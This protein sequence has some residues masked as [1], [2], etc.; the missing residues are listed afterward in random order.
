M[1]LSTTPE[2]LRE[3]ALLYRRVAELERAGGLRPGEGAPEGAR[4]EVGELGAGL[5]G[6]VATFSD[7]L[8]GVLTTAGDILHINEAVE[9]LTGYR[10]DEV[11]GKNAW[12]FVD[13]EDLASLASARSA[14]LDDAIPI[15]VRVRC[16]DGRLRR[17]EFSA[18]P[19]PRENPSY[20]V[21]RWRDAEARHA[22]GARG[23]TD[24][25]RLHE[26][27]RRA[28][29]VARVSQ[30]ALFL[31]QLSDVLDA[32][33]SLAPSALDLPVGAYLEPDGGAL[34][35]RVESGVSSARGLALPQVM[36]LAGL[37]RAGGAPVQSADVLRDG[38][39]ADSLLAAARAACAVAVPV[40][41]KERAH[42]V[43]LVAGRAVRHFAPAEV[44][45]LETVANV[46]A[47]S[48]DARA[49]QE[50]LRGRE[51]LAR[52]VFDHARDGLAIVDAD[53]RCVDVN[54]AGER[55]LGASFDA[56]RGQRPADVVRCDLDLSSRGAGG[57]ETTVTTPS[58]ARA[59]EW[60]RVPDILPGVGLAVLRD[61]TERRDVQTRL[62]L[63]DR[64]IAAGT[65]AAGVAHELNTPLAYVAA[66]LEYLLR[67]M[68]S[69]SR[70][71]PPAEVLEALRESA[72][73]VERLRVIIEDLRTFVGTTGDDRGPADLESVLRS[74][75]AMTW[76][77]I[78]HRARLEK[79]VPPLR[80]VQG[81]P[82]RLAQVFVNLL[83]NAAQA[84]REGDA[85]SNV[86]RLAAQALP[87]GKVAVEVSDTG[88]GIPASDL[89]RV[90]EPFF[91]TKPAGQG[92]GLGLSI[93]R[94]IVQA[95]GGRIDVRSQP[96]AGTTVRVVLPAADP[97][98]AGATPTPL[99]GR[100]A[101]PR[102]RVLVVD[103]ERLVG[104]SLR[105]ALGSEHDV[106]VVAS[107]RMALRLFEQGERFDAVLT[108][109]VM[110]DMTGLELHRAIVRVAPAL[111]GRVLF[112]TA[113]AF[114][115]EARRAMEIAPKACL[116]KP[117]KLDDLRAALAR[118]LAA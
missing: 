67:A 36:T 45:F 106:T 25:R 38:R 59:V 102:S 70:E 2:I 99:P 87:D 89:A 77:D 4:R 60:E 51:R 104:A 56:L 15:E 17:F 35:V 79:D 74:C 64:M 94:T 101:A 9:R 83:V 7:D 82:A 54:S 103:D 33:A 52:A 53:G 97:A 112:M 63:A 34:V 42:G 65:L 29:A 40:R 90:F 5:H 73:G 95:L 20:I 68:P 118:V 37:A 41:G 62:A 110:P 12:S 76:N 24:A 6:V 107:P 57:G 80:P 1:A 72:E 98:A 3:L 88:C 28:A 50:A 84:I 31:P 11:I 26:E 111:A 105:R 8:I 116:E 18:R 46:V 30:L 39:L 75:V 108:D 23:E 92:T 114:T 86:I 66:N 14:P 16:A 13:E 55:I 91:T 48:I 117:V 115:E 85:Q 10:A 81:N 78:R 96:G 19:W 93:C 113:G 109:L 47:T 71:G 43:L 69:A 22:E 49:A 27:L 58:G 61:V 21:A 44:H 32:A 100:L